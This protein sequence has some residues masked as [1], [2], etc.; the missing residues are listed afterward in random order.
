M[1]TCNPYRCPPPA[2][3]SALP[4]TYRELYRTAAALRRWARLEASHWG[5]RLAAELLAIEYHATADALRDQ[6]TALESQRAELLAR[7]AVLA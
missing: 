2:P 1:T 7:G 3:L 4:A 5:D 6:H